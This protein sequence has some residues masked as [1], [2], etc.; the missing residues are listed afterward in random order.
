MD[1]IV[2]IEC[3]Y[4]QK[5]HCGYGHIHTGFQDVPMGITTSL[6]MLVQKLTVNYYYYVNTH[7]MRPCILTVSS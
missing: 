3:N 5:C 1:N 7:F 2:I 4:L 6:C